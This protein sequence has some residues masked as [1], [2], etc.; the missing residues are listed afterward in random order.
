VG[1]LS[2]ALIQLVSALIFMYGV[3]DYLLYIFYILFIYILSI[4]LKLYCIIKRVILTIL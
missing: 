3:I 4:M 2:L 1:N